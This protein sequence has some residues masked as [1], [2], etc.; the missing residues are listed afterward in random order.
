MKASIHHMSSSIPLP[1]FDLFGVPPTQSVIEKDIV[2][3]HRPITSIDASSFVQF[4]IV[5]AADEYID[6][7]KL[8]LYMKVRVKKDQAIKDEAFIDVA[9][10]NYLLHSVIKQ[11]DIFI[12]DKQVTTTSPTYAYKAY[13]EALLG[14][15]PSAKKSY[16]TSA[17]WWGDETIT[18]KQSDPIYTNNGSLDKYGTQDYYGRLHTDLTF[19][20]RNLLGG[21]KLTIRI[22][23]NDPRFYMMSGNYLPELEFLDICLFVHRSK[24]SQMIVDAHTAALKISTAKYPLTLS[25]VKAFTITPSMMDVNL[26]NVHSGQLPKRIFLFF[27]DNLAY[28]GDYKK[29][30][31]YFEHFNISSLTVHVD[32]EQF[33][34]KALTPDF[35]KNNYVRELM[36][37]YESLDMLDGEST[38]LIDRTYYSMGNVIFGFNFAPDLTIGSAATGYLNPIKFGSLRI[39]VKFATATKKTITALVYC[40]F[41]KL[42][43]IDINRNAF[44]DLF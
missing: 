4:E 24:V 28:N 23:F 16:L 6:L 10:V 9:P 19:Q 20:G 38:V 13:I 22:L 25:K 14:F 41:D 7:E 15:P 39:N 42:L 18:K 3:E 32:G 11:L 36:S 34:S 31:F 26:D 40:E 2:T 29:N 5:S 17:G 43:E 30:P 33:P 35:S 27:V 1:K 37:I 8:F 21:C 12:G 44:I